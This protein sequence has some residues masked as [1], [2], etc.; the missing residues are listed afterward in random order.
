MYNNKTNCQLH[1][2]TFGDKLANFIASI[3]VFAIGVFIGAVDMCLVGYIIYYCR[4]NSNDI[5]SELPQLKI[6]LYLVVLILIVIFLAALTVGAIISSYNR[7]DN[8]VSGIL[9]KAEFYDAESGELVNTGYK[10]FKDL[11]EMGFE[12]KSYDSKN[13]SEEFADDKI[14]DE[15]TEDPNKENH[16]Q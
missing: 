3:F 15:K 11:R 4:F 1:Q 13:S 6:G 14:A 10:T 2:L 7:I 9:F 16:H 8:I 12:F 5:I